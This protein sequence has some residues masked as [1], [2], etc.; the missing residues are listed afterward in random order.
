MIADTEKTFNDARA[1][2]RVKDRN[3][4]KWHIDNTDLGGKGRLKN[5]SVSG[6]LLETDKS[7]QPE[8]DECTLTFDSPL[9]GG[10]FIPQKGRVVWRKKKGFANRGSLCGV[11]FINPSEDVVL[12]LRKRVQLG[13]LRFTNARRAKSIASFL[14][15]MAMIAMAGYIL[16]LGSQVYQGVD[17]S[18]RTMLS[19]ASQQA[20]V[21]RTY[22]DQLNA[23]KVE[24]ASVGIE[25]DKTRALYQESTTMLQSV[26]ADLNAT[27][28]VLAET[29]QL[30]ANSQS[31]ISQIK[32][33]S[34]KKIEA[35]QAKLE[36]TITEMNEKNRLLESEMFEL[37][38]KLSYL[39]GNVA[40]MEE[41]KALISLYKSRTKL[42]KKKIK[43]FKKQAKETR[44]DAFKERDRI[45]SALGNNGYLVREGK[46]VK[47]DYEKFEAAGSSSAD[48]VSIDVEIVE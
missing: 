31:E 9:N 24:L 3:R 28:A 14:L 2:L 8:N 30:L 18:N 37:Q 29:K 38:E 45:R 16:W 42:V 23:K 22:A 48:K 47:V 19:T 43:T 46:D 7:F 39:E 1:N 44:I 11:E 27:K 13:I 41:G 15:S 10:N 12:N 33:L 25:L 36:K 32:E 35:L 6:M 4:V 21:T 40:D 5:I 26:T 34:A 17:E 20:A